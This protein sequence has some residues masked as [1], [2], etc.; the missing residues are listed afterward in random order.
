[1]GMHA[2]IHVCVS[3]S[4]TEN[5]M[6]GDTYSENVNLDLLLESTSVQ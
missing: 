6:K 4:F 1:M 3:A 2:W 5:E